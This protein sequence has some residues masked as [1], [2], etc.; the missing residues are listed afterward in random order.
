MV[1]PGRRSR[2][3][4]R[5]RRHLPEAL[6]RSWDAALGEGRQLASSDIVA[7]IVEATRRGPGVINLSLGGPDRD[8]LIEQAVCWRCA[9]ARS[10][11]RPLGTK[12]ATERRRLS[13]GAAS[14]PDRRG[15]QPERQRRR[16]STPSRFVDLAAPG[17]DMLVASAQS[18]AWRNGVS[19]TSFSAPLV[20]GA[21]AWVW[22]VRPELDS[23]Q[24][25]EV[26]RRPARDLAPAGKDVQSGFGELD[27]GR[28]LGW[29]APIRDLAEPNDD[30]E[31]V[32]PQGVFAAGVAPLTMPSRP[33]LARGSPGFG[34]GPTRRLPRL[35][36]GSACRARHD[37]LAGGRRRRGL[38]Q[39]GGHRRAA[40]RSGTARGER[41]AAR[42][43]RASLSR[44]LR[45]AA[46]RTWRSPPGRTERGVPA[47]RHRLSYG[48]RAETGLRPPKADAFRVCASR[49][50]DGAG[51]ATRSYCRTRRAGSRRPGRRSPRAGS[52][53]S[54]S[55]P[56]LRATPRRSLPP[57]RGSPPRA[58][59]DRQR[60][61]RA[62]LGRLLP[63]S[64]PGGHP[65][66]RGQAAG[67]GGDRARSGVR[68]EERRAPPP[69][70]L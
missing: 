53:P 56:P 45:A 37:P 49:I 57:R 70:P 61:L 55:R 54:R 22:T 5:D 46:G 65:V 67:R 14:R 34:R 24:L 42:A 13:G 1:V 19:G 40:G 50:R 8:S 59:G 29:P 69:H 68:R 3:R 12:G 23:G 36:P 25:F 20:S 47:R 51:S 43:T 27:V 18:N 38:E 30:L 9:R 21:A 64:R 41:G 26:L 63:F 11:S 17:A 60:L 35:A 31:F 48:S 15:D 7:G 58:A 6:L 44:P 28:A 10:S 4:R 39:R 32:R 62:M 16:F 2:Q 66:S 33:R 52:R